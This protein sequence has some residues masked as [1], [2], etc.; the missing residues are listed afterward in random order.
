MQY[1]QILHSGMHYNL[2]I[3][4]VMSLGLPIGY[5]NLPKSV[6]LFRQDGIH[7]ELFTST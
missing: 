4:N 1:T 5:C 3:F 7:G 2:L 6:A